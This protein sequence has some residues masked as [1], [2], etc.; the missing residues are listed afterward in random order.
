I[1]AAEKRWENHD[2]TDNTPASSETKPAPT[3]AR[4]PSLSSAR[5]FPV[6]ACRFCSEGFQLCLLP[7]P[8]PCDRPR[9]VACLLRRASGTFPE[10]LLPFQAPERSFLVAQGTLQTWPTGFRSFSNLIEARTL[11][12]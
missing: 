12:S 10:E 4:L 6:G 3:F 7:A 9:K 8:V 5:T 1:E 2:S 11:S